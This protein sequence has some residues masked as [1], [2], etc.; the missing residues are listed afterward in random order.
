MARRSLAA[1]PGVVVT[2]LRPVLGDDAEGQERRRRE[3]GDDDQQL[4]SVK[5]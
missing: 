5:P 4:I 2:H 1:Q 3:D